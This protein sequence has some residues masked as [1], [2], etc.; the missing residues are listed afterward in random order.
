M[1]PLEDPSVA[2]PQTPEVSETEQGDESPQ[3][4]DGE[5]LPDK[6][7]TPSSAQEPASFDLGDVPHLR[8][9]VA[10][11][12]VTTVDSVYPEYDDRPEVLEDQSYSETEYPLSEGE[13]W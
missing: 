5:D 9:G 3:E 4:D 13:E 6:D 8:P 1:T 11:E 7:G 2:K 10:P 12:S